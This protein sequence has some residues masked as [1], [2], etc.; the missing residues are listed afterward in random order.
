MEDTS[1]SAF[2]PMFLR[3]AIILSPCVTKTRFTPINGT[4]SQIVPKATKSSHSIIFGS[5]IFWCLYHP[6]LRNSRLIPTMT[7]KLTPMAASWPNPGSSSRRF[8]LTTAT[9]AGN[10]ASA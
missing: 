3:A 5:D 1:L 6:R 8:G 2:K 9:A 7:M 4:I 10:R